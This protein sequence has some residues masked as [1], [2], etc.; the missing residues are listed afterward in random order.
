MAAVTAADVKALREETG[1]PM[2]EC[3]AAL[4]EAD[5]DSTAAKELLQKKYKGKMEKRSSNVTGEGR[6]VVLIADDK[7][8]GVIVDLRCETDPVAKTER[9]IEL[10]D[11]IAK[12]VAAQNELTLSADAVRALPSI[13][14]GKTVGNEIE[15][16]FGL[17]RENIRLESCRKLVGEYLCT[18]VHH[19]GKTGVLVALDAVP[20]PDSIGLDLC[21]HVTFANPL[22][23]DRDG[24]PA[25]EV[26]KV[27]AAA[28]EAAVADGKPE[29]I[30]DKIVEG[31]VNAFYA[32]NS[33]MEQEHVK[34]P[35]TKVRDV[36]KSGGV[37][38]VTDL[39][40][41]KIG[42]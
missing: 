7:K 17:L 11:V 30:V 12:S 4:S 28:H 22:S 13:N 8:S 34:V 1:L 2:M 29:Q 41:V 37:N 6:V 15:D 3:K 14:A 26:E 16:A 21:H 42:V 31:K 5:G 20:N 9:F 32:E 18:Y 24:V 39:A 23:I 40:Y 25:D 35:K 38:A 36:L 33:L 10:G 27:R 19:D